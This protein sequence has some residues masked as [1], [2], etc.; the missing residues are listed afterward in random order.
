MLRNDGREMTEGILGNRYGGV[1][2]GETSIGLPM[3]P[4]R[5]GATKMSQWLLPLYSFVP[6]F[7]FVSKIS[8]V[9]YYQGDKTWSLTT[10][11]FFT[12][13]LAEII[14]M[15]LCKQDYTTP[16]KSEAFLSLSK[17]S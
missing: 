13:R 5:V 11:G 1:S 12:V 4:P 6:L 7:S 15:P 2:R 9:P 8:Q 14:S 3:D 17:Y 16:A 10:F